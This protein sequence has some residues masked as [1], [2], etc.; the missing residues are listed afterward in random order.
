MV[1]TANHSTNTAL[2]PLVPIGAAGRA[3]RV[4]GIVPVLVVIPV[5]GARVVPVPAIAVLALRPRVAV[6]ARTAVRVPARLTPH[7]IQPVPWLARNLFSN[8]SGLVRNC[9]PG[10]LIGRHDSRAARCGG[11]VRSEEHTSE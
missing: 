4:P 3:V 7:G 10:G 1:M 2:W 11:Q 5:P 8:G 6:R 9:R